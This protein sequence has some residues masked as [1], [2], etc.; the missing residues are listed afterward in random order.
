MCVDID[1]YG[2][3][4]CHGAAKWSRDSEKVE[5]VLSK[6]GIEAEKR[7]T[8]ALIDVEACSMYATA[9]KMRLRA[10]Q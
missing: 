3:I 6:Y 8:S 9:G 10:L 7:E 2:D 5:R 4:R 1:T